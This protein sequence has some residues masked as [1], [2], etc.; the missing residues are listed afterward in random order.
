MP[1]TTKR[2]SWRVIP[3]TFL[4]HHVTR[5]AR[6]EGRS[7]ANMCARLMNESIR[8][9]LRIE[10]RKTDHDGLVAAIRGTEATQQ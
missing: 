4:Q 7:L 3:D 8:A 1:S 6:D 10:A 2:P 9:R 5:L